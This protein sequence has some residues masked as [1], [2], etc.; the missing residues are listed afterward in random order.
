[1]YLEL[2]KSIRNYKKTDDFHLEPQNMQELP[3]KKLWD[4]DISFK[5]N[6]QPFL[7]SYVDIS[8]QSSY[9]IEGFVPSEF[10]ELKNK[11]MFEKECYGPNGTI[12]SILNAEHVDSD[13]MT[14]VF[15]AQELI[16]SLTSGQFTA[17]INTWHNGCQSGLLRGFHHFFQSSKYCGHKKISWAWKGVDLNPKPLPTIIGAMGNGNICIGSNL[18]SLGNRLKEKWKEGA[19][20]LIH[21]IYPNEENILMS[22][23][24]SS[25]MFVN[26]HGYFVLRLPEP[27]KWNTNVASAILTISMIFQY[28]NIW[29]SPWG[30]R[31]GQKK[32]YVIAHKKKKTVYKNNHR[33]LVQILKNYK[34]TQFLKECVYDDDEVKEWIEILQNIKNEMIDNA[35]ELI[36]IENWISVIMNNF[37][38]LSKKIEVIKSYL[39]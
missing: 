15:L 8:Q 2:K 13:W 37:L 17:N 36:V 9:E 20:I 12:S 5:E 19:D 11:D 28:V 22:G 33:E 24:L 25:L 21:D 29:S 7:A 4:Y 30:R 38:K 1:M 34:K 3:K 31:N 26:H 6:T 35:D 32:Y 39:V 23:V 16:P 14:G 27:T 10:I 18:I